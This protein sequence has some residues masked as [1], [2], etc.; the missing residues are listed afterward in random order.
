MIFDDDATW[1]LYILRYTRIYLYKYDYVM[2][3]N[4]MVMLRSTTDSYG[5]PVIDAAY[6]EAIFHSIEAVREMVVRTKWL[7]C[8]HD[9]SLMFD[10]PGSTPVWAPYIYIF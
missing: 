5:W 3:F 7:G 1:W 10:I 2:D 8:L 4:L 6:G 9:T